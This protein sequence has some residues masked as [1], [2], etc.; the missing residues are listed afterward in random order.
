MVEYSIATG[1]FNGDGVPDFVVGNCCFDSDGITVFLSR[2]DGSMQPGVIYGS[3]SFLPFVVVAD[4][5][6]DGKLDIAAVD[7]LNGVVQV[8]SGVGDGTFS[9]SSSFPTDTSN[10]YPTGRWLETSITTG[11]PT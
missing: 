10:T 1:D 7:Y 5:N 4:F 3:G 6:K 8:F 9:A 11:I 2:P